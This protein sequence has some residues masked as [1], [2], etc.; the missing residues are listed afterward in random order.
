VWTFVQLAKSGIVANWTFNERQAALPSTSQPVWLGGTVGTPGSGIV[1]CEASGTGAGGYTVS[2]F[3]FAA[4]SCPTMVGLVPFYGSGTPAPL[5]TFT[6][7]QL[8]PIPNLTPDDPYG[9]FSLNR[10][11]LT[12][13]NPFWQQPY[14]P[15]CSISTSFAW[16]E[17]DGTGQADAPTG[18]PPKLFYAHRPWVMAAKTIPTGWTLPDAISL[19]YDTTK[20]IVDPPFYV[21]GAAQYITGGIPVGDTSSAGDG[22]YANIET[23]WGFQIKACA[24]ILANGNFKAAYQKF[25]S[26]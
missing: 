8:F 11:E 22:S 4:N 9:A 25:V 17:D 13:V 6:P 15:T 5:E 26:C 3:N 24:T 16:T 18:S 1:G 21:Y 2:Q 12:M 19:L 14:K 7:Q 23:N 10:I 20:N